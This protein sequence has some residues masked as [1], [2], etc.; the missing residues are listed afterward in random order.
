V[1]E[2]GN[3]LISSHSVPVDGWILLNTKI[4]CFYVGIYHSISSCN[5]TVVVTFLASRFTIYVA[6]AANVLKFTMIA[7]KC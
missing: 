3:Q 7:M 4:D 1:L 5:C 2:E 6:L